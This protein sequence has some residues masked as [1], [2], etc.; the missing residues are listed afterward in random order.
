MCRLPERICHRKHGEKRYSGAW[1]VPNG[2]LDEQE[3]R[4]GFKLCFWNHWTSLK[5][6]C[7]V[8][9]ITD[10]AYVPVTVNC[11]PPLGSQEEVLVV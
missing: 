9:K 5:D 8:F 11:F 2:E 3:L 6:Y 4:V 7:T 1:G 10:D